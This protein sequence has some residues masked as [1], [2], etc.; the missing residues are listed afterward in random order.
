MHSIGNTIPDDVEI[1]LEDRKIIYSETGSYTT[2]PSE[3]ILRVQEILQRIGIVRIE[4]I[5]PRYTD[6]VPIFRINEAPVKSKCH[7]QLCQWG[8]PPRTLDNPPRESL[9]KGMS[10]EQSKASALMEAVERYC[11]QQFPHSHIVVADYEEVRDYATHSSEFSFPILPLKCEY[12]LERNHWCFRELVKVSQEWSWGF[13][14]TKKI[15]V[16][17]P[18]SLVYYPYISGKNRSFVF[19][20]TGG[21]SAGNTIEE[22]ILQGIAEVIERDALYYAFNRENIMNMPMLNMNSNKNEHIKKFITEILPPEKFFCFKI[23]NTELELNVPTFTAFMC[24][25]IGNSR[26]YFGGSGTSLNHE[27]AL[28]RA[29][30]EMEQQKVM[31]KAFLNFGI[32][33]LVSN[34]HL[35]LSE[36]I[37]LD[38]IANQSTA[39]TRADI[40]IYLDR[41]SKKNIDVIVIN[42]TH[43]EIKIP[44]VRVIIPKLISYCGNPIKESVF[45]HIMQDK[46][47][48]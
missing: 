10:F 43:P 44:V 48:D 3:T 34:I 36:T 5:D 28:L 40:E 30:T 1:E 4:M 42:L 37:K 12:C 27:V 18:S 7:R 41:L 20:D 26:H 46:T 8:L 39:N 19:N 6:G 11:A 16:L 13:S 35:S 32:N 25:Q 24:H 14:L 29:L 47:Y 38:E 15:P 2:L 22:A 23:W 33:K 9:G 21:L 31:K 45:L 17:V